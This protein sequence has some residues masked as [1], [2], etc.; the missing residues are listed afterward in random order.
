MIAIGADP[1][2]H[3][4]G[5]AVTD[6]DTC[7]AVHAVTVPSRYTR[8]NA[9]CE[10]IMRLK[11][12]IPTFLELIDM[13]KRPMPELVVVES[14]D[15]YYGKNKSRYED[16]MN[17]SRVAGAIAGML[18]NELQ[19]STFSLL[20]VP[21]P[22]DWKGNRPKPIHQASILDRLGWKYKKVSTHSY[23]L[24]PPVE[25]LNAQDLKSDDWKEVSDAIGLAFW[26][27]VH[28]R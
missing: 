2:T 16:L 24:N 12:E 8:M 5:L 18:A 23:P 15:I 17:L 9:V 13:H 6:R 3:R 4:T 22:N 1:G 21:S 26:G 11:T 27:A 19:L 28:C 14:Q 10:M 20:R 25:V 7:Y